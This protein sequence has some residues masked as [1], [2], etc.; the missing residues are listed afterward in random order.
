MLVVLAR[1]HDVGVVGVYTLASALGTP[2]AK[3]AFLDIPTKVFAGRFVDKNIFAVCSSAI[4]IAFGP[5][6]AFSIPSFSDHDLT[7]KLM[8]LVLAF[9][10]T[11]AFLDFEM[12]EL[13]CA[14][15]IGGL[16]EL[17]VFSRA[18]TTF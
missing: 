7:A 15:N 6:L 4:L 3:F 10:L 17:I 1:G 2:I 16:V 8:L 14:G 18:L 13:K 11:E 5:M 9:R 12:S